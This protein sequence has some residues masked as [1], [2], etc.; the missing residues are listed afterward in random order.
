[1]CIIGI[2]RDNI[3]GIDYSMAQWYPK[4]AEYDDYGWHANPYIGREFFGI[5][6][7]FDVKITIDKDYVLGATGYLQNGNEIGHGY[8]NNASQKVENGKLTW[9]F[10]APNV[11]DF[12]WAADP[13]YTHDSYQT[14]NGTELHFFLCE[15]F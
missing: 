3:E 15:R 12:V 1:M 9:H 8:S 7:D 2:G 5:W 13:D 11:H 10:L 4:L 6:G 14:E